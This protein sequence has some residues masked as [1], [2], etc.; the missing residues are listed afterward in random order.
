MTIE[1]FEKEIS[2]KYKFEK[3]I[4]FETLRDYLTICDAYPIFT[5]FEVSEGVV[6]DED[7]FAAYVFVDNNISELSISPA[8]NT[9]WKTTIVLISSVDKINID[10]YFVLT[11]NALPEKQYRDFLYYIDGVTKS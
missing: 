5:P 4:D 2:K 10:D 9:G 8:I 7:F 11:S 3:I 6:E 1:K